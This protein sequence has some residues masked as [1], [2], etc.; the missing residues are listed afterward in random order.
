MVCAVVDICSSRSLH[1]D[2][3]ARG[4]AQEISGVHM[5]RPAS[6]HRLGMGCHA[7]HGVHRTGGQPAIISC[8]STHHSRW[9][10]SSVLPA[11]WAAC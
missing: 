1:L 6:S 11:L 4:M 9:V 2:L 8:D 7:L 10:F 3:F 5:A